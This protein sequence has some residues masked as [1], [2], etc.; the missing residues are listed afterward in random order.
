MDWQGASLSV[1]FEVGPR[2]VVEIGYLR[3][4]AQ[5]GSAKLWFDD[6][7]AS[8]K[9]LDG[10]WAQKISIPDFLT[11]SMSPGEHRL[12]LENLPHA[13]GKVQLT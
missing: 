5:M 3:S 13:D 7:V 12:H 6:D 8:A 2:G 11:V 1:V 4:Y 10:R 9:V